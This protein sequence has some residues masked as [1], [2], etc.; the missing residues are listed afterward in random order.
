MV[1]ARWVW[2][3][4]CVTLSSETDEMVELMKLF[5]AR[6]TTG[7]GRRM[8]WVSK[9]SCLPGWLGT[10]HKDASTEFLDEVDV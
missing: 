2:M 6:L 3:A 1:A 10:P 8:L 4:Y 7:M 5:A 9:V